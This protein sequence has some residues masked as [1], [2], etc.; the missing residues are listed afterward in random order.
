M[1]KLLTSI[2]KGVIVKVSEEERLY[3]GIRN[4]R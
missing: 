4:A 2:K 3:A 1:K